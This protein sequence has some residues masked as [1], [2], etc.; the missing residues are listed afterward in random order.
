[1][2]VG[3]EVVPAPIAAIASLVV[4]AILVDESGAKKVL[5]QRKVP[6]SDSSGASRI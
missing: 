4:M 6:M 5:F 3:S 2:S 1:M